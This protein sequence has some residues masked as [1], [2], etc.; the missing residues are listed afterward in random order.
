MSSLY[1]GARRAYNLDLEQVKHGTLSVDS[2]RAA[3]ILIRCEVNP[4]P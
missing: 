1:A 4:K 3:V 2:F